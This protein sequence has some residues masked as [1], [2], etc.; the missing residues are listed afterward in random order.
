MGGFRKQDEP[1]PWRKLALHTW[2]RPSDPTVY[3]VLEL[4]ATNAL[5]YV[6]DLRACSGVHV[7]ITHLVG[8]AVALA[9]AERPEVNAV[10]RRGR[11]I[12]L[13][14]TIDVFFQVA[15]DGG[16]NL[17]GAKVVRADEKGVAEIA[18]ELHA[19]SERLRAHRDRE[20]GRTQALLSAMPSA[21]RGLAMHATEYLTYDLGLDLRRLGIPYDAFGSAMV[22]NVGMFG[23][24]L[25]FAPLLPF[26]RAP[27]L[28][29]LGAIHDAPRAV[30]G[31]VVVRP[32]LPI[33]ATFDHRLLDGYQAGRLAKR[34]TEIVT[35]PAKHLGPAARVAE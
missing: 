14:D 17:G 35:D 29:T 28:L 2:G 4:D 19:K 11:H 5:A 26:S 24:P 27:I 25:G 10:V 7:T 3:G 9:I 30:E 1:S 15:M 23:L 18:A 6:G 33:G 31:A 32:V 13:R 12:H 34:F 22:T 21:V 20:I 8:K 16:E